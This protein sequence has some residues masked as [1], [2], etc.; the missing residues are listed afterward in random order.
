MGCN[1]FTYVEDIVFASKIKEDHLIDLVD[2]FTN[3][4]EARLCLNP[5]KCIFGVRQGKV[6][7]CLVSHRGIEENPTKIKALLDMKPSQS[8]RDV[9]KLIGRLA[10]LNRF[11]SQSIE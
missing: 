11:I 8:A 3:M 1:V 10:T 6:M 2:T 9:Q 4:R 5:E 7:G